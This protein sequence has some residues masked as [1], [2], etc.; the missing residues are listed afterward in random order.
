M[1]EVVARVAAV[2]RSSDECASIKAEYAVGAFR[3]HAVVA[4]CG[5]CVR[6]DAGF[7]RRAGPRSPRC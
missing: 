5:R 3:S 6:P 7:D 2:G 1:G 4:V